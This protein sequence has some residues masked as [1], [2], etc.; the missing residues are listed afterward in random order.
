MLEA[1]E[2][3]LQMKNVR[4]ADSSLLLFLIIS[5]G[6]KT[7]QRSAWVS[8]AAGKELCP[9]ALRPQNLTAQ[10]CADAPKHF[11]CAVAVFVVSVILSMPSVHVATFISF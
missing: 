7:L 8:C 6:L 3:S 9:T 10:T 2:A 5:C 4:S 11:S 1:C